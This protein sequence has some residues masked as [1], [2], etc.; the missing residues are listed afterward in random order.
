MT[1]RF[2]YVEGNSILHRLH[3]NT[4]LAALAL[5]FA[6]TLAF[7]HPVYVAG[8]VLVGVV[9]MAVAGSLGNLWR[10]A[11][12]FTLI[13][14]V[15]SLLWLLFVRDIAEP[16]VAFS[17]QPAVVE[18]GTT[19]Y[20]L[21]IVMVFAGLLA[22]AVTV[23]SLIQVVLRDMSGTRVGVG[24]YVAFWL[25]LAVGSA[26]AWRGPGLVA[27]RW[28]W[29]LVLLAL[30]IAGTWVVMRRLRT[31]YALAVWI[32]LV[33]AGVGLYYGIDGLLVHIHTEGT[34]FSWGPTIVISQEALLYG[35][36]MG[37]RIVAFLVFGLVF[38][39]TTSPEQLTQGLRAAGMPLAP[40]VALSLAFRLAPS[41][42]QTART[43]MQAQRARGLDLDAGG[44]VQRFRKSLPAVVPTLGYALRSA[45]DLTRALETRGLGAGKSRTEYRPLKA[46]GADL[47]ALLVVA[48]F[49]AACIASRMALNV[50]ELLP[51]L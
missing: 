51:R 6:A 45:D 9:L 8:M 40:S 32:A 20:D 4:K 42:A 10:S 34:V 18:R 27:Q 26:L 13:F 43:V 47:A 19:E 11:K 24:W 3:P 25:V 48:A 31:P 33:G 17:V 28:I 5:L 7:N 21:A 46:T 2:L 30:F 1:S 36:A 16:T 15:S 41:F 37:L 29:Y 35:P 12:F 50:G 38:I 22:L 39:S 14:V 49:T 23:L 44:P